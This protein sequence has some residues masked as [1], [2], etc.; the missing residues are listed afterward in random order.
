MLEAILVGIIDAFLLRKTM[1]F[2]S[3]VDTPLRIPYGN[4]D[5]ALRLGARYRAGGWYA[6][7]GVELAAFGRTWVAIEPSAAD[8]SSR[9]HLGG[10]CVANDRLLPIGRPCGRRQCQLLSSRLLSRR[11]DIG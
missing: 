8:E 2:C 10:A 3:G 4:K 5:A 9:R 6:P 1:Q 11:R 7:A